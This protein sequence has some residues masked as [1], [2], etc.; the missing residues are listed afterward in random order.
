M[1]LKGKLYGTTLEG[2][3]CGDY[4]WC[5]TVFVLDP[6]ERAEKVLLSF[7]TQHG[8]A[9]GAFPFAGLTTANGTLFGTTVGSGLAACRYVSSGCGTVFSLDPDTEVETVLY[10]FCRVHHCADGANPTDSVI[11]VLGALYATTYEGGDGDCTCGTI[12]SV[13]PDTHTETVVYAFCQKTDC[14][15]GALPSANLIKDKGVLYGTTPFGGRTGCPQ[16]GGC[17]TVFSLDPAT[18]AETVLYEFCS[19]KNCADGWGPQSGLVA[20]KKY[21]Y[22]TTLNGGAYGYGVVF[23]VRQ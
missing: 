11:S 6:R 1:E 15:D 8:C 14:A 19:R 3:S 21:L 16:T 18:G 7:C 20:T 4:G 12:F 2:G 23:A 9:D 5:G 22:G 13:N 17:G 10:A